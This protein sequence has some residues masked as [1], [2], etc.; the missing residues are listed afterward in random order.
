M[1][2]SMIERRKTTRI[3]KAIINFISKK[4]GGKPED[5]QEIMNA[6]KDIYRY[7][8]WEGKHYNRE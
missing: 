1:T 4:T 8:Y 7:Q 5:F 3:A 6:T 2:K